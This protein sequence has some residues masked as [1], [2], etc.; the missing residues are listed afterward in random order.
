MR[1]ILIIVFIVIV[2]LNGYCQNELNIIVYDSISLE[3]LPFANA[4]L[5]DSGRGNSTDLNGFCSIELD[6]FTRPDEVLACS[7]IGFKTKRINLKPSI[8][9]TLKIYLMPEA[10]FIEEVTISG[11]LEQISGEELI[12]LAVKNIKHNYSSKSLRLKTFYREKLYENEKL[13]ELNESL[14]EIYYTGYPQKNYVGKSFRAYWDEKQ[15]NKLKGSLLYIG[16]PQ[17]F[18]YYNTADD[19]CYVETKRISDN[20]SKHNTSSYIL[21]GPLALT[22]MDKV[23]YLADFVDPNLKHKY[24]FTR[25]NAL[26]IDSILCVAIGFKPKIATKVKQ[27]WDKKIKYP[28]YSGTIYISKENYAV[29]KFECQFARRNKT[30]MYQIEQPWQIYPNTMTLEVNYDQIENGKWL[31]KSVRTKQYINAFS[32]IKWKILEDYLCIRELVITKINKDNNNDN[33]SYPLLKDVQGARL[34]SFSVKNI[35]S[36]WKEFECSETFDLLKENIIDLE[37]R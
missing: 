1:D 32:N 23:K 11:K 16:F 37:K 25:K 26:L 18:K 12:K 9:D 24:E 27:P 13:I 2:Q 22:A 17:F 19:K 28:L 33:T 4:I 31:L 20:L 15:N 5:E 7:Y 3:V 8:I 29:V 30:I 10:V 6:Q 14:N 34:R 21:G 35:E 36:K